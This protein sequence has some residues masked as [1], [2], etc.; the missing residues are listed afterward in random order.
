MSKMPRRHAMTLSLLGLMQC[1]LIGAGGSS[2]TY[3]DDGN[4]AIRATYNVKD[5][6]ARGD[7]KT[8]DTRAILDAIDAIP[9][10]KSPS[11]NRGGALFFPS[12]V[13]VLSSPIS[14][15]GKP[16][17]MVGEGKA[18]SILKWVSE[19]GG[20]DVRGSGVGSNDI[21]VF[22]LRNL[23]LATAVE[24][25]GGTALR[26]EWPVMRANPQKKTTI[27]NVEIR[28]WDQFSKATIDNY[29]DK[30]IWITNPGGLDISHTDILGKS[31]SS[32]YGIQCDSPRNSGP[33]RHFL[34]NLYVLGFETGI[35]WEG[36]NEGVYLN[37]FEIVNCRTG[38]SAGASAGAGPGGGGPVYHLANGHM[39]CWVNGA[40]FQGNNEVK[41]QSIAFYHTPKAKG[42]PRMPGN[43]LSLDRCMR[44]TVSGCSFY[45]HTP[46]PPDLKG[47]NG[48][49]VR[50]SSG[51]IMGNH[52]DAIRDSPVRFINGRQQC[53]TFGNRPR[54]R[55]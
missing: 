38:F 44:F 17:S 8:D 21:T 49:I 37:N 6:G 13:Y 7:G 35:D 10:F 26:L 9:D 19:S 12:G 34:S 2:C 3:G 32:A 5:Y 47:Q 39:D 11:V 52:F 28:G 50:N 41:L 46:S 27:S 42:K 48:I 53:Q 31:R 51:I 22:E 1:Y 16:I 25:G 23:T 15:S 29:W 43:L 40:I 55:N 45:G 24:N 18:H 36:P 30:G 20:I 4:A 54:I 33:I 14:I